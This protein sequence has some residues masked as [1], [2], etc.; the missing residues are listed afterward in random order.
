MEHN[1]LVWT[2]TE[3]LSIIAAATWVLDHEPSFRPDGNVKH[4]RAIIAAARVALAGRAQS[5][6]DIRTCQGA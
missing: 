1:D 6:V 4:A 2:L 3:M 5:D